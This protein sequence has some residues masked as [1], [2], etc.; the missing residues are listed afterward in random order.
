MLIRKRKFGFIIFP[1]MPM[2]VI[3]FAMMPNASVNFS[4]KIYGN[5][6]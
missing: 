3:V 2:G 5:G 4:F 1:F 6:S